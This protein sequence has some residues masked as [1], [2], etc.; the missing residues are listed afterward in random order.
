MLNNANAKQFQYHLY[1]VKYK[2]SKQ[3][4][5]KIGKLT[6]EGKSGGG[7]K[8]DKKFFLKMPLDV[9]LCSSYNLFPQYLYVATLI[10]SPLFEKKKKCFKKIFRFRAKPTAS[11]GTASVLFLPRL[12]FFLWL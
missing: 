2:E 8:K 3:Q 12:R 10:V 11:L 4:E 7:A 6:A 9:N 1:Q 5:K